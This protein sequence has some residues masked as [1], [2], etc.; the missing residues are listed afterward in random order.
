[1][2]C[3][4]CGR[5]LEDDARS[6]PHCGT[7]VIEVKQRPYAEKYEQR[8]QAEK[9][10]RADA[11]SK[12]SAEKEAMAENATRYAG[13]AGIKRDPYVLPV[14]ILG[15][16]SLLLIVFPWPAAWGVGTSLW[17]RVLVVVMSFTGLVLSLLATGI[18]NANAR[19]TAAW[20]RGHKKRTFT[21]E[22]PGWLMIGRI[23]C[24][25]S[26]LM[27]VLSFFAV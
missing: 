26:A 14:A 7:E 17:M 23:A 8:K 10:R 16:I 18:E 20:N 12:E 24:A 11:R 25:I 13:Q 2:Y 5:R 22:S 27:A 19:A 15:V 9:A 1:M 21:Y 6:C 3:R 4:R